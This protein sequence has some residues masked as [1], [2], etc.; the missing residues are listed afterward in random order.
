[1]ARGRRSSVLRPARP[2]LFTSAPNG[3]LAISTRFDPLVTEPDEPFIG[4]Y[5]PPA[6]VIGS[7]MNSIFLDLLDQDAW[8]LETMNR[9]IRKVPLAEREEFSLVR[10]MT[11]RPSQDLGRLARDFESDLPRVFR[12]LMRGLGTRETESPDILSFLL[13]EPAY[14]RLLMEIGE[15]DGEAKMGEVEALIRP[16]PSSGQDGSKRSR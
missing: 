2:R 16:D 4:G 9:L 15:R 14:L 7:L 5:P 1:M 13:F 8:R 12:F 11:L 10:L 3:F 6:Q